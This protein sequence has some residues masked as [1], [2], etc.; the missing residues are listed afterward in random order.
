MGAMPAKGWI[1][2]RRFYDP[3]GDS[4]NERSG[5]ALKTCGVGMAGVVQIRF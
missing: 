3:F 1:R 4:H 2:A 5:D